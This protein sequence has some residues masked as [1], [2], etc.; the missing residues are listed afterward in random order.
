MLG[1]V[2]RGIVALCLLLSA[3]SVGVRSA[4]QPAE[5]AEQNFEDL[6]GRARAQD[7]AGHRWYPPG[8]N[9]TETVLAL[10]DLLPTATPAQVAELQA[11][12]EHE[13][14]GLPGGTNPAGSAAA[15]AAALPP[16]ASATTAPASTAAPLEAPPPGAPVVQPQA[17]AIVPAPQVP[18][19]QIPPL[20]AP[21]PVQDPLPTQA[22]EPARPQELAQ[23]PAPARPATPPQPPTAPQPPGLAQPQELAQK[24]ALGAVTRDT[25]SVGGQG[26]GT[27]TMNPRVPDARTADLYARGQAAERR[28]DISGARRF[29]LAA[30]QQ[31]NAAAARFL[32]RLYDPEYLKRAA[33][34]GVDAD[35]AVAREWYERAA[36]LGDHEAT[37]LLQALSAR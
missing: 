7:A 6:L 1:Q 36:A 5:A 8:D 14:K 31:G 37:P 12:V 9:F 20:Q 34:G 18:P 28:G 32:G 26:P 3:G 24:P 21:V 10:L 19:Q 23:D 29:Y 15:P 17:S 25:P 11:L 22:P 4:I 13:Q 35:L 33:I 27:R 30:A 2:Q 16:A